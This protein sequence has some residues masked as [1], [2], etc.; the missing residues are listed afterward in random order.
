MLNVCGMLLCLVSRE[1]VA[2]R[3][4]LANTARDTNLLLYVD[5]EIKL[6][7]SVISWFIFFYL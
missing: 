3:Y 7:A 2:G 1:E 6:S 4:T 5:K